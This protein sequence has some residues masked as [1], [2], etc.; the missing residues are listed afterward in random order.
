MKIR[1]FTLPNIITLGNLLCGCL[2]IWAAWCAGNMQLAFVLVALGCVFDFMD[3]LAARL[4]GQYSP[5]GVQLDSLADMVTFG[6]A[7]AATLSLSIKLCGGDLL[8]ASA[9]MIVPLFSALR[10]A[11]FN[12]DQEQKVS[13]RGL[14][15]PAN[16]LLI[17]SIGYLIQDSRLSVGPWFPV[18]LAVVCAWLLIC[19][20]EMFSFK[21]TSLAWRPNAVR[22]CFAAVAAV[23][24]A[25]MDIA[26]VPVIIGLYIVVSVV[27]WILKRWRG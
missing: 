6:V 25:L 2:A 24:L 21:F 22:Y 17:T 5:L 8:L 12:I 20:V 26:A 15:T 14:P 13:F 4:L 19:P 23:G 18:L 27:M 7:P 3:G 1:Y 11:R 16:A 9:A 10:L